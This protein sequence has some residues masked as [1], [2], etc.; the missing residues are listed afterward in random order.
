LT[1]RAGERSNTSDLDLVIHDLNRRLARE[2][3][4]RQRSET[5]ANE[6][7]SR[8]TETEQ[9]LDVRTRECESACQELVL[10]ERHL[11]IATQPDVRAHETSIDLSGLT[12]LYVG[13]R[14]NHIPQIKD[15]VESHGANFLHHDGGVENSSGLIPG[16]I[17][18]AD[19]VF[20]P[21]D[22]I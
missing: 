20:F 9:T 4:R 14:P 19:R 17:S 7:S 16:L 21:I 10:F 6:L 13:G 12:L 22:C 3:M 15:L 2:K 1:V 8:L 11:S 5:R 18:R